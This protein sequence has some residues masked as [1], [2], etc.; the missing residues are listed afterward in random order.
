MKQ[1]CF[2]I[3]LCFFSI[4]AVAQTINTAISKGNEYYQHSQF[5]LAEAE[6]RKALQSEPDN[7]TAQYNLANTLQKQKKYDEAI[8]VLQKLSSLAKDN[9]LRS[10]YFYNEGVAHTKQKNLEESIEAYKKSLRLNPDDQ[11]AR[12]NLQKA[13]AEAKK[14]QEEQQKQQKKE[15]S[16]MSKKEAEQ[17]L[18]LLQEKEKQLQQRLQNQSKEKGGSKSKDW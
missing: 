10:A 3:G 15:Q 11:Q 12:E 7:E 2:L 16:S 5:E 18:K 9:T 14:K 17:K 1:V 4:A 8:A 13:L 6:Y